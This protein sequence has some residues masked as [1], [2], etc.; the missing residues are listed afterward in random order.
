MPTRSLPA[1]TRGWVTGPGSPPPR[2]RYPH[3]G[4]LVALRHPVRPW[5]HP[6]PAGSIR[7]AAGKL[8]AIPTLAERVL[9]EQRFY[10]VSPDGRLMTLFVRSKLLG[11]CAHPEAPRLVL[12][13]RMVE[14]IVAKAASSLGVTGNQGT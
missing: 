1:A 8:L 4:G 3:R 13:H 12:A 11:P 9:R 5:S 7:V 14:R 2:W 10:F 6:R